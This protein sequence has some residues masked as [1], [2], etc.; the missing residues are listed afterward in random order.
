MLT[1]KRLQRNRQW[2]LDQ[3]TRL[4][5]EMEGIDAAIDGSERPGLGTH[6]ADNA[7]EVFEQAR[8]AGVLLRLR[9]TLELVDRALLKMDKGGYG[10]CEGCGQAIDPARLKALPHCSLCMACQSRAELSSPHRR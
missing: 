9:N 1:D 4:L 5:A 10:T 6:M 7:S 8:N 2:L 3:R